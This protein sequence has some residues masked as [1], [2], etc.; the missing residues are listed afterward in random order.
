MWRLLY[1]IQATARRSQIYCIKYKQDRGS[2][3]QIQVISQVVAVSN[4]SNCGRCGRGDVGGR[5]KESKK[6]V[7]GKYD[8]IY[9]RNNKK[10]LTYRGAEKDNN[11]GRRR[12]CLFVWDSLMERVGGG[13]C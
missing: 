7:D 4:T 3:Y 5:S 11:D 12:R 9:I 1:Q 13:F 6:R 2:L 10:Q 8:M